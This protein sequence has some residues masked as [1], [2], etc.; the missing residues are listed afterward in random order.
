MYQNACTY[1]VVFTLKN[2]KIKFRKNIK[3]IDIPEVQ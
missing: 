2:K 3:L 1:F